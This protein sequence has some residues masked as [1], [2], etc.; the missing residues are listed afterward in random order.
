MEDVQRS[1]A[2]EET[3]NRRTVEALRQVHPPAG[4]PQHVRQ[5]YCEYALGEEGEQCSQFHV[6][7]RHFLTALTD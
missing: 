1:R 6:Q 2:P 3:A 5:V 7:V 4:L